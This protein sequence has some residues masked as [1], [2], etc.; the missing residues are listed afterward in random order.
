MKLRLGGPERLELF[1]V[2]LGF[3]RSNERK[4]FSQAIRIGD[5]DSSIDVGFA[6][7]HEVCRA[8]VQRGATIVGQPGP[9]PDSTTSQRQ[10]TISRSALNAIRRYESTF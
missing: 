1:E 3:D 8:F 2:A 4:L 6:R 5:G 9:A 10:P 7:V